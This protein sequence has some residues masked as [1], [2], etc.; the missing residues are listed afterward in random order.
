MGKSNSHL[1]G[2]IALKEGLVTREQ[3]EE[4][5]G[6]QADGRGRSLGTI[7]LEKRY[8][9]PAQLAEITRR[10]NAGF[11]AIAADPSRGGLFGQLAM[12]HGYLS[13]AQLSECLREQEKLSQGG[14]S[15]RLGQLLIR[16]QYLSSAHF[17]EVLRLQNQEVAKCPSC[18]SFWDVHA[19]PDDAQLTC[20]RCGTE[21]RVPGVPSKT[22]VG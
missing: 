21:I 17:L 16:K 20:S 2:Q 9:T 6:L 5:V 22:K 4:C 13:A 8:L 19:A 12:R 1:L 10:Q 3:L 14:S 18:E 11:E 7:L 15:L